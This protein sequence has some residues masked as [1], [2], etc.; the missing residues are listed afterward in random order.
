MN[1]HGLSR[2]MVLA[3]WQHCSRLEQMFETAETKASELEKH[4]EMVEKWKRKGDEL[5]YSMMPRSVADVVKSGGSMLST[6]QVK[7]KLICEVKIVTNFIIS[8]SLTML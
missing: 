3:G 1:P 4:H 5:L 2:E 7:L 8:D 6:C